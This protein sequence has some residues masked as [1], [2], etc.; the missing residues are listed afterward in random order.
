VG[1]CS[2]AFE[3]EGCG[4]VGAQSQQPSSA[5][6]FSERGEPFGL[7]WESVTPT[8]PVRF[9][10]GTEQETEAARTESIGLQRMGTARAL[11]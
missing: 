6:R 10:A 5:I 9:T 4:Q 7:G 2:E 1:W 11:A 8:P 3:P